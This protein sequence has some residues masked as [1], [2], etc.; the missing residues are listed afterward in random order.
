M[1]ALNYDNDKMSSFRELAKERVAVICGKEKFISPLGEAEP[2]DLFQN[3]TRTYKNKSILKII[4]KDRDFVK[5][6]N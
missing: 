3:L 6:L 4:Y 1:T 5:E 2:S